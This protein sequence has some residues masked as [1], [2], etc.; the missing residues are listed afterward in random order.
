[1]PTLKEV[2]ADK[3]K[4]QDSLLWK[5]DDTTS[6]TLG[7]LRQLSD[8]KQAQLSKQETDMLK[9]QTEL[10][11]AD[12]KLKDSQIQTA[13]V[14]TSLNS[15]MEAIK[16]GRLNDPAVTSL[17]GNNGVPGVGPTGPA[18]PF[19]ELS[20][21]E[22]DSLM[23]PLVKVLKVVNDRAQKAEQAVANNIKVQQTMATHYLNGT[24]EDRYDRLVPADKQDKITLEALIRDAVAHNELRTDSTPDIRKAYIRATA[25]DTQAE[26]DK[27]VAEA[28]IKKYQE[29]HPDSNNAI[30]VPPTSSFFGLDVHNRGGDAAK[31]FKNLDEAFAA[32]AK[33]KDIWSSVDQMK[34]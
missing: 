4:Y 9:R 20:R 29:E 34:N 7:Q 31:P 17:F 32:A 11:A 3:A 25:A 19:A 13:N 10:D 24:L 28:A 33:D 2:L 26:H 16:A 22:S 27:Q 14:F 15:A 23:G 30:N 18:D 12:R 6:V 1:M 5:F 21:L 8:E